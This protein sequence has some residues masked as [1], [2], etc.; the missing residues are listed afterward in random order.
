ML[1]LRTLRVVD[2]QQKVVL[3]VELWLW[4][5]LDR[6]D[7]ELHLICRGA[8]TVQVRPYSTEVDRARVVRNSNGYKLTIDIQI[9]RGHAWRCC[10][11]RESIRG[12]SGNTHRNRASADLQSFVGR[13]KEKSI[14]TAPE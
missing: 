1:G 6:A 9:V 2:V 12:Q 10:N 7:R 11:S 4:R 5:Q 14:L 3:L 8:D 13:E